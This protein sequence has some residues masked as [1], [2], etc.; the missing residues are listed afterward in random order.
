MKSENASKCG[1][2]ERSTIPFTKCRREGEKKRNLV[3]KLA[4]RN[5]GSFSEGSEKQKKKRT[6][7]AGKRIKHCQYQE[8]RDCMVTH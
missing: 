4:W 1:T 5:G 2:G 3:S 8:K 7:K 6:F